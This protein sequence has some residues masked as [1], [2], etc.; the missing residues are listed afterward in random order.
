MRAGSEPS[1]QT[2]ALEFLPE[3]KYQLELWHDTAK[4]DAD[5]QYVEKEVRTISARE[6]LTVHI[7]A[8]SGFVA[9]ISRVR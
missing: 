8:N 2:V 4:T 9:K 1:E 6:K 5:A 7:A 3:G